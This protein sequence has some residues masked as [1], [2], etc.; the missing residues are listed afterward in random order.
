MATLSRSTKRKRYDS[1]LGL[2]AFALTVLL[3]AC[4]STFDTRGIDKSG[5][6][7]TGIVRDASGQPVAGASVYAYR[8]ARSG[9]R[10][11]ADFAATSD[12][13]GHYLLDL[14]PGSYHLVARLRSGGSDSGPPRP[15]DAW[16][17]PASNP[18]VL[19]ENKPQQLDFVLQ[20]VNTQRV[21]ARTLTA[22]PFSIHGR[23]I[24]AA[25]EGLAATMVLAYR[26]ADL[27]RRPDYASSPAT[28]DGSFTLY[29]PDAGP[30]CLVIRQHTRGQLRAGELHTL[31]GRENGTCRLR[32]TAAH[33]LGD[34]LLSPYR[35]P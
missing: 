2:L 27:H 31:L 14:A 13:G 5:T 3:A 26:H 22:A 29:L 15:G 33:E 19:A 9:L 32:A 21:L 28:D 23:A 35:E 10:G 6:G 34:V 25:G 20:Q 1:R 17:L 12:D 24:D 18:V 30:W 8:N 4:T 11:P 16:A 7:I